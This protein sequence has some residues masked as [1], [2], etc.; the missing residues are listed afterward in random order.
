MDD[1]SFHCQPHTTPRRLSPSLARAEYQQL[2]LHTPLW[3]KA[4]D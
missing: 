3:G 1:H 4:K 2:L